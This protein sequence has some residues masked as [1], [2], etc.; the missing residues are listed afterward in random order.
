MKILLLSTSDATGGAAVVSKRLVEALRQLG[1]DARMLVLNVT[2]QPSDIVLRSGSDFSRKKAFYSERLGIFL[3]NGL[4]RPDLFKVSTAS[5]GVDV[6][7]LPE[8]R[9]ADALIL[10]WIN[11]GFLSLKEIARLGALGK[12]MAWVM[13]DMW[14]FTGICHL[15]GGCHRYR[16]HCGFCP[17]LHRGAGRDDLSARTWRRKKELYD[18]LPGLKFVAVSHWLADRALESSLLADRQVDVIPNPMTIPENPPL[19]TSMRDNT[20]VMGAARLDDHVKNLPLAVEALNRL[21]RD[22]EGLASE[23]RAVFFGNL[24]DGAILDRLEMPFEHV[25][26]LDGEGVADLMN[27]S[28]VVMS[29][30][31]FEMLPTTIVEGLAWGC[32]AVATDS[33]GQRDIIEN[34]VNGL[35]V[36]DSAEEVAD[37]LRQAFSRQI[38]PE[39]QRLSVAGRFNPEVIARKYVRLLEG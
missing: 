22:R 37:A 11:Q 2:G 33:G 18:A 17:L 25:G 36:K 20:V 38:D 6:A 9:E 28:R 12:P 26:P 19:N 21:W 35:L 15:S 16:E 14:C 34:G 13:H 23:P 39:R 29:T 1:H 24:R 4:N 10:G 5:T 32:F 7:R 30:S 27:R 3:R 8:V 31:R